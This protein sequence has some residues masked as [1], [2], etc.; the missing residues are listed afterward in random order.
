[1]KRDPSSLR[2]LGMTTKGEG[3]ARIEDPPLETAKVSR[4]RSRRDAGA[5]KNGM[6][7]RGKGTEEH[8]ARKATAQANH[9]EHRCG[10]DTSRNQANDGRIKVGKS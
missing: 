6:T 2:S 7:M 3:T 1:M 5:A 9:F 4:Q 8:I 10:I